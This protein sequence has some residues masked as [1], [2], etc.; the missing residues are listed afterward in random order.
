MALSRN[1]FNNLNRLV[2]SCEALYSRLNRETRDLDAWIEDFPEVRR[3]LGVMNELDSHLTACRKSLEHRRPKLGVAENPDNTQLLLSEA[4]QNIFGPNALA[5]ATRETAQ[6]R[7]TDLDHHVRV[8]FPLDTFS[9]AEV[10]QFLGFNG[11]TGTI[12][13]I[14][15]SEVL[16]I[17]LHAGN[18]INAYS[19]NSPPGMR[20]GEI[21][22][23]QNAM[24]PSALREFLARH[25][26]KSKRLGKLL[27]DENIVPKDAVWAALRFQIEQLFRRALSATDA[28]IEFIA[29][30]VD[31]NDSGLALNLTAMLLEGSA[32]GDRG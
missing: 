3:L 9:V 27:R 1:Q 13:V 15:E 2:S 29:R 20:L 21:L 4:F 5:Q 16:V 23:N 18:L 8:L 24:T 12:K 14:C 25:G 19:T 22:V 28:T 32:L 11:K 26:G 6:T 31:A 7:I 30:P 17:E 10:L